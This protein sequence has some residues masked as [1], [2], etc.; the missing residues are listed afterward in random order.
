MFRI[1][2]W[3]RS[4]LTL[5]ENTSGTGRL[6]RA[7][8]LP[9]PIALIWLCLQTAHGQEPEPAGLLVQPPVDYHFPGIQERINASLR[10][11]FGSRAEL[12]GVM[13]ETEEQSIEQARANVDTPNAVHS[14]KAIRGWVQDGTAQSNVSYMKLAENFTYRDADVLMQRIPEGA[15]R[16]RR[17]CLPQGVEPGFLFAVGSL[18]GESVDTYRRSGISSVAKDALRRYVFSG[19]IFELRRRVTRE[20][21]ELAINDCAFR[22]LLESSFE[23]RNLSNGQLSHFTITYGIH[24]PIDGIPVRIVYRPRW[25]FEA[26]MLLDG[27]DA[28]SRD[29]REESL[30]KS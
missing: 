10:D 14:F 28:V 17:L 22:E 9:A 21:R 1:P 18:V 2:E 3:E 23:A 7:I 5:E 8:L 12:V 6:R 25:W 19:S 29:A 26:E 11:K 24:D 27:D 15:G 13:T 20:V 30:W 16:I 4:T